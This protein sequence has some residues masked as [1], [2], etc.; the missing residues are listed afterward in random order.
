MNLKKNEA[1]GHL[2]RRSR[3]HEILIALIKQQKDLEL[4]DDDVQVFENPINYSEK[5]DPSK[6][7]E[8][9][10]RII[11]KY[12]SLVR[13]ALALDALLESEISDISDGRIS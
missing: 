9:N 7:V 1:E 2:T 12:Q 8:R 5:S 13:S 11:K 4:M 10:R 3:L 6:I